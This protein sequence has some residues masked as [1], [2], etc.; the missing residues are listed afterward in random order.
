M[1]FSFIHWFPLE[2]TPVT[3]IISFQPH[4]HLV[5]HLI[6]LPPFS[7]HPSHLPPIW[8]PTLI[9]SPP[10]LSKRYQQRGGSKV[11]SFRNCPLKLP[12]PTPSYSGLKIP[13]YLPPKL[14]P[15][16]SFRPP[17]SPPLPCHRLQQHPITSYVPSSYMD[18][19]SAYL[20][21]IH[22]IRHT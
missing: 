8:Q 18:Q 3:S 1:L 12:T 15:E 9:L 14:T 10:L 7:F 21:I 22:L 6:K 16:C 2:P 4:Q 5:P 17:P 20:P 11:D 19:S 13:N